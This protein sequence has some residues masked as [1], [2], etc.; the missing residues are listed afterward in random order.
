[1]RDSHA[2]QTDTR[3]NVG[4]RTLD[5]QHQII[6]VMLDR[7]FTAV[8][9][10]KEREVLIPILNDFLGQARQH[11]SNE[12]ELMVRCEYP[13]VLTHKSSHDMYL[14]KIMT[15]QKNVLDGNVSFALERVAYFRRWFK[16]HILESDKQYIPFVTTKGLVE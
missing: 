11:F 16:D 3:Y 14:N 5:E 8:E 9:Q 1:M 4:V 7:L 10:N 12:E 15:Y 2:Q 13:S 6:L